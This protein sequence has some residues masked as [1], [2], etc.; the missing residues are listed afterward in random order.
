MSKSDKSVV[1]RAEGIVPKS[2]RRDEQK[3]DKALK[4]LSRGYVEQVWDDV[5]ELE[6]FDTRSHLNHKQ[7]LR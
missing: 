3:V 7:P 2:I 6:Q 1:R 5:E 4:N